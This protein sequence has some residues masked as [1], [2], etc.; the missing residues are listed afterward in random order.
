LYE[1]KSRRISRVS[2]VA[3]VNMK[4]TGGGG[5]PLGNEKKGKGHSGSVSVRNG[6]F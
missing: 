4:R 2:K 1:N 3:V 6:A 5:C